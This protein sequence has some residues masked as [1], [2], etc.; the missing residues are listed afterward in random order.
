MA[1]KKAPQ[2]STLLNTDLDD[3]SLYADL[4]EKFRVP[5]ELIE[6]DN[7]IVVD[8]VP[9]VP[10]EKE[11]KLKGVLRK[12]FMTISAVK[13]GGIHLPRGPDP[14]NPGATLTHGYAFIEFE[15]AKDAQLAVK[16]GD[17]F[18]L[19]K[20]HVFACNLFSDIE[21]Y[22]SIPEEFKAP[23]IEAYQQREHLRS[24]L[25]DPM[26]RDQFIVRHGD[27]SA[28][29]YSS[30]TDEPE[31]VYSRTNWTE[32]FLQWSPRGTYLTTFHK[33]GVALW[34]GPSW[35]RLKRLA[36]ERVR[37]ILWSPN[38]N[39]LITVSHDGVKMDDG[40]IH[41]IFFWDV[42]TGKIVK[43][44]GAGKA[45]KWSFD[46]KYIARMGSDCINV[47]EMP[48]M[49]LI[50]KKP[51]STEGIKDFEWSPTEN[52]IAFWTPES[53][54]SPARVNFVDIPSRNLRKAKN[55]F[56]VQDGKL[57]WQAEGDFL[58][59]KVDRT[60]KTK[61]TTFVSFE[62]F[63]VREKDIPVETLD[64]KDPLVAFAWEPQGDKFAIVH[65]EGNFHSV[66]FYTM[67]SDKKG[68]PL[69]LLKTLEKKSINHL[70]WCPKGQF[71]LL[72]GLKGFN[73]QLEFWNVKDLEQMAVGEH[74]R[75]SDIEW[76]PTGR[77]VTSINSHWK[78]DMEN[79]YIIWDFRGRQI[80]ATTM[81]K[82]YLFLWRPRPQTLLSK[83]QMKDVRRNLK[84][85][86]N[87]FS[88][89]DD[90]KENKMSRI[91]LERRRQL[92]EEWREYRKRKIA[93]F[94]QQH[95]ERTAIRG[96]ESDNEDDEVEEVEEIIEE[97]IDER[98]I[99]LDAQA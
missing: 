73:G 68:S 24:W 90:L 2:Q 72:A 31:K 34:G 63:R 47:F 95:A 40:E 48:S 41:N 14:N 38:E 1:P 39:Y 25:L 51:L 77:Y 54:N 8:N 19:D 3:P 6:L 17:G 64:L 98:K 37:M 7:V 58:A 18:R 57:Y 16:N 11:E 78:E 10:F 35:K 99:F 89:M 28:V 55:V 69:R 22:S 4:E 32:T 88:K 75:C 86:S 29:Y 59:F 93:E 15:T 66:S 94:E 26:A 74:F 53:G 87:E 81:D 62:F 97:V 52:V 56:N 12:T 80:Y 21:K 84:E 23:E 76:D 43:T 5:G 46:E 42:R 67:D 83:E 85:Y 9:R 65:G 13:E 49:T 20:T 33:Q 45:F 96:F 82:F 50:D 60:T 30:R 92:I 91:V 79:G 44:F 27:E 70:Y 71:L 36:H 61:K